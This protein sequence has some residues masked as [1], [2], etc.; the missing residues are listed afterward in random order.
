M[1]V[2]IERDTTTRL[3]SRACAWD[4]EAADELALPFHPELHDLASAL[5]ARGPNSTFRPTALYAPA[6]KI[7]R[8]VH[9]WLHAELR[10]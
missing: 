6:G 5:I 4:S 1:A 2:A 10:T 7:M 9:A 8:F 3:L